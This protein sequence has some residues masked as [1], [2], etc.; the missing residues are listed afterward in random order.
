MKTKERMQ[1]LR[2]EMPCQPPEVR[3]KNF[4]EV[5]Y[6]YT[7]EIAIQEANR[8]LNC[9][10]PKCV[11]GCP[12]RVTIP[13][14]I[15]LIQEG[16][17]LEAV[18]KIKETNVL[19]AICGRVCPQE[20]QCEGMCIRGKKGKSVAIGNLERFVAD[21]ERV[22]GKI[23]KPLIVKKNGKKVAIVGSGPSGLTVAGDLIKLGYEVTVFEAFHLGG[24]VLVY[25]I[26]EFRLPKTVVEYEIQNLQNQG[27]KFIYNHV[28]GRIRSIDELFSSDGFAAV[29]IGVGAGLPVFMNIPGENLQGVYSSNEYLTRSVLMKAY[30]FPEYDTPLVRG[31]NVAVVGGGNV[32]MD[33]A[34]TAI[35]LDA[36]NVHIVYRR[37]REQMPARLEEIHHAEEE[38]IQFKLLSNPVELIS[39]ELGRLTKVR[40]QRYKLGE[41][42][43]SGRARPV[44]I[45]GD[46]FELEIDLIIIAIGNNANPLITMT[47][48]DIEV[49]KWGNI[50]TDE[51]GRTSKPL[52]YAGGDIVTG[53]A[54]VIS[55]M[56]AGRRAAKSIHEDLFPKE[57]EEPDTLIPKEIITLSD[58]AIYPD[59]TLMQIILTNSSKKELEQVKVSI[60]HIEEFFEQ[61]LLETTI[62]LW[63]PG[64]ENELNCP[65]I[66]ENEKEYLLQIKDING[67]IMSKIIFAKEI[68]K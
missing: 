50:V 14:F 8:C 12:V 41:P 22:S 4:R 36:K 21:Y 43:K 11:E 26:P 52:V 5:P 63:A 40:C 49:N 61:T 17:F 47:T 18:W 10:K 7:E 15:C 39:D 19:P 13:E 66:H 24:G 57:D 42:D 48:P 25:G 20:V 32:A 3:A 65:R 6:G 34:R 64:E 58:V 23:P 30:L 54:T 28:I 60:S 53:A 38:G 56:G 67:T 45:E 46:Y 62:P 9:K 33:S 44:P 1:L 35:R 59:S 68:M 51:L 37:A 29:Y 16:K 2:T 31:K 27:V 55:A